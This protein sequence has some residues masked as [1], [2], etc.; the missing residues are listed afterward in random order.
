MN[1]GE[2]I[3]SQN[4]AQQDSVTTGERSSRRLETEMDGEKLKSSLWSLGAVGHK[5]NYIKT[6]THL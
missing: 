2:E 6:C 4:L 3:R 1:P 5:L